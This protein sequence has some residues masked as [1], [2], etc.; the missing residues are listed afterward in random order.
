MGIAAARI[1]F[2]DPLFTTKS[3][4]EGTGL[5][6]SISIEILRSTAA[7]S[8]PRTAATER[9]DLHRPV[10]AVAGAL[11]PGEVNCIFAKS[12]SCSSSEVGPEAGTA[13]C[14]AAGRSRDYLMADHNWIPG[15]LMLRLVRL[16]YS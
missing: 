8:G 1:G 3:V 13:V 7:T 10:A 2:F 15:D 6:L 9:R 11:T 12:S 4:G 5:G 16:G 14:R